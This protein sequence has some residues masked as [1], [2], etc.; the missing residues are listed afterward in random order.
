[1]ILRQWPALI[2]I[3]LGLL[4]FAVETIS[5]QGSR[6]SDFYVFHEGVK[7]ALD[8]PATLYHDYHGVVGTA[9]RLLGF[10]YPPPSILMLLPFGIGSEEQGFAALQ[11]GALFAAIGALWIWMRM[12]AREHV[13][14]PP[15]PTRIALVLF[16]LVTGPVF[17]CRHGQVDTLIL[18][19]IVGGTALAWQANLRLR[20]LGGAV[21]AFGAWVKIYPVLILVG[22][23][24]DKRRRVAVFAGFIAGGIIVPLL[25]AIV[26]PLSVWVD[27]FRDMLPA[28]A[29]RTIVNVDN[30]SLSADIMRLFWVPRDRVMT[31]F[32]AVVVPAAVRLGVSLFGLGIIAAMQWR[33]ERAG[34]PSLIV[35]GCVMAVISL[36][37]PLG[38]GHS[39]A[40]VL[41]LMVMVAAQAIAARRWGWLGVVALAWVAMT[42][43]AHRH[44]GFA[45]WNPVIWH[46]TYSRYALATLGLL[47][48]AWALA[49]REEGVRV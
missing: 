25:A 5:L 15:L 29:Q 32:D 2:A 45:E 23:L 1:M 34:A 46:L 11:W 16:A 10:L 17:T 20:A 49:R 4:L 38:W 36:I 39:Y 8:D 30:Q 44:F 28:M 31:S 33:V 19:I 27:F 42:I 21:L 41:P 48:A 35:A 7:R 6:G 18:F 3:A 9:E 43:P 12:L 37:A 40:Y 22:L 26:F 13:A 14:T 47:A 24:F